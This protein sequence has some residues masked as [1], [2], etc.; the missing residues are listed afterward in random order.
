MTP[1]PSASGQK[2]LGAQPAAK[3]VVN[4]NLS[5]TLR[6]DY[7][8]LKNDM[9]QAQELA[10]DFQRQLAGKSNEHAQ[11]KQ[12]FEKTLADLANLQKG[13]EEL[14]AERHRLA[15]EAM[16]ATAFQL[17]LN[18]VTSERD[19][20]RVDLEFMREALSKSAGEMERALRERDTQIAALV[21]E[22]VTLKEALGTA[23]RAAEDGEAAQRARRE[24]RAS[25]ARVRN[26]E[27]E[28]SDPMIDISFGG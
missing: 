13:I 22:N 19:K 6:A 5:G 9:E 24:A 27:A 7:E 17:K 11:L 1:E 16:R 14:R 23:R 25:N 15:N 10:S 26:L 28:Q 8:A 3:E 12:V 4:P 20:L 21:I 2:D 18:N